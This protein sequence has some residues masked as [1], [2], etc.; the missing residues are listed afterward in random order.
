MQRQH[1]AAMPDEKEEY[2][3][4]SWYVYP[5]IRTATDRAIVQIGKPYFGTN[6]R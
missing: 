4:E 1:F 5:A 6:T 2:V 3:P